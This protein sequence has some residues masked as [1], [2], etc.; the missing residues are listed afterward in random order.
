VCRKEKSIKINNA[1]ENFIDI[2]NW[3]EY[4]NITKY[5]YESLGRQTG[6]KIIG[7]GS[8]C[9]VKGKS[10]ASHQIDVLTSHTDGIHNYKTAIECKYWKKKVNKD[11]VLK[12]AGI[13]EDTGIN[14]GVIVSKMGFTKDGVAVANSKNIGLVE[15]REID[16]K[17][18]NEPN[19]MPTFKILD[20]ILN[21]KTELRRPEILNI[22]IDFINPILKSEKFNHYLFILKL[23]TGIEVPF[24]DYLTDF[25]GKLH[26]EKPD[27]VVE[28]YYELNETKLI[29]IK[30]K[31]V[32]FI[33]GITIK[34][35][36]TVINKDTKREIEII[37]KVWMKMKT[38]F[39]NNSFTI[40]K[41]GMIKKDIK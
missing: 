12:I 20:L 2:M 36:L 3:K 26:D 4:E 41:T 32:E 11:V 24:N 17:D 23:K 6:V 34:G 14:K 18:S 39:E 10:G 8:S 1:K 31:K 40:S 16:E 13:I 5:I 28:K 7:H 21:I 35:K 19:K 33:R 15:L 9:H 30:T 27:K 29:N 37:D 22:E 25:R 38:L